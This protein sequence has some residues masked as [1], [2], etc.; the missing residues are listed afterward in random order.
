MGAGEK[1]FK[2]RYSG[3]SSSAAMETRLALFSGSAEILR[4]KFNIPPRDA[5]HVSQSTYGWPRVE[6]FL[7]L[8]TQ[9]PHYGP[10]YVLIFCLSRFDSLADVD[11]I[12][13]EKVSVWKLSQT[14]SKPMTPRRTF[15]PITGLRKSFITLT[16]VQAALVL[17]MPDNYQSILH[18]TV[19]IGGR[20][21]E[22]GQI[23]SFGQIFQDRRP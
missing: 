5:R 6:S 4:T 12:M 3:C 2:L 10:C 16:T 17:L 20:V 14:S 19:C 18:R 15:R 1:V 23:R 8:R 9:Y 22:S 11:E 21:Q 13:L 7:K